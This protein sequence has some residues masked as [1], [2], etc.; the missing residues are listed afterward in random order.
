MR[1]GS[2][3]LGVEQGPKLPLDASKAGAPTLQQCLPRLRERK[4]LGCWPLAAAECPVR[5]HSWTPGGTGE[6]R[7]RRVTRREW[8]RQASRPDLAQLTGGRVGTPCPSRCPEHLAPTYRF[9]MV[10]QSSFSLPELQCFISD[11]Q[12]TRD[13]ALHLRLG[14]RA[15][16]RARAGGGVRLAGEGRWRPAAADSS[17]PGCA[18]FL[19][20]AWRPSSP[21]PASTLLSL[22]SSVIETEFSHLTC[23]MTRFVTTSTSGAAVVTVSFSTFQG[24]KEPSYRVAPLPSPP[25]AERSL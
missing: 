17:D 8:Q 15:P 16:R 12:L 3:G 2:P 13:A 23:P 7:L 18:S 22:P 1:S 20:S 19:S 5:V 11:S 25:W 6:P 9:P 4:Q 10:Q 14:D 24:P 21:G